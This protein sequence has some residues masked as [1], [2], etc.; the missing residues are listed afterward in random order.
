MSAATYYNPD[1]ISEAQSLEIQ[2]LSIDKSKAD[3]EKSLWAL[4][5]EKSITISIGIGL[6][7]LL[8]ASIALVISKWKNIGG[9]FSRIKIS[10]INV[11]N[12]VQIETERN[13]DKKEI[14]EVSATVEL[15]I[16][17]TT[18]TATKDVSFSDLHD[19]YKD[20]KFEEG[21]LKLIELNA[22]EDPKEAA[23]N[24]I[25]SIR[26]KY[27]YGFAGAIKELEELIH[28]EKVNEYK[29]FAIYNLGV[30]YTF[31]NNYDIALNFFEQC[32][33]LSISIQS[34][35]RLSII[36]KI[37]ECKEKLT[38]KAEKIS[39]LFKEA[40]DLEND[41][42]KI[43]II[44][45]IIS[46]ID[47]P[48]LKV[49]L[50]HLVLQSKGNDVTLLFSTAYNYAELEEHK[51]A[52]TYYKQLVRINDDDE[53]ALNNLGVS[54]GN[55][56]NKRIAN[57]YFKKAIKAGNSLAASNY[58]NNLIAAGF[59][60]E[61][62]EELSK[63]NNFK[64]VHENFLS[65]KTT[66]KNAIEERTK[67]VELTDEHSFKLKL[68]IDK[69]NNKIAEIYN[70]ELYLNDKS[71]ETETGDIITIEKIDK[72]ILTWKTEEVIHKIT[73]QGL[74]S[75]GRL[76]YNTYK[77]LSTG[78]KYS[79]IDYNGLYYIDGNDIICIIHN[80]EEIKNIKIK[81]ADTL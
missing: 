24:K 72:Y 56:K 2:K 42:I 20:G 51:L 76:S 69:I 1:S 67:E 21:D 39:F 37:S 62:S 45:Y 49:V 65:S 61:A 17:A 4:K 40:Y 14:L 3:L 80:K 23:L 6:L 71:L 10:K 26:L 34:T 75:Y 50:Q 78:M 25:F 66:L 81:I 73:L 47:D 28:A 58:A 43:G 60:D 7:I 41:N 35:L 15:P 36:K 54:Y 33:P 64:D 63:T 68:F 5:K 52:I 77:Q 13:V 79:E 32:L 22:K 11:F 59:L 27:E 70:Q 9:F 38:S 46:C 30:C 19:Y 44:E 53:G 8:L 48:F 12:S 18:E 16:A 55:L 29:A 74:L 57:S 31:Q